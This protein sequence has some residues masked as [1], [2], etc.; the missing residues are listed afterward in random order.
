[1]LTSSLLHKLPLFLLPVALTVS[2]AS[3]QTVQGKATA[4]SQV[5][6]V[7]PVEHTQTETQT[8]ILFSDITHFANHVSF[9]AP[10]TD[11]DSA[12]EIQS[13]TDDDGVW[14]EGKAIFNGSLDDVYRDLIDPQIIGP[15]HLTKNIVIDNLT[16]TPEKTTYVMH[17]KMRYILQIA[18]DLSAQLDA[19]YDGDDLA[20]WYYISEKTSGSQLLSRITTRVL[21][22]ALDENRFSVEFRSE[23]VATM[24]KEKESRGHLEA[25]FDYW[26]QAS[27]T[28]VK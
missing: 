15:V 10:T 22:H 14:V 18:F 11:T 1:M 7:I 20:G 9:P 17:V 16:Q 21:V 19:L 12:F 3:T 26:T 5:P 6:A 28:R 8:H 4:V 25:L 23:N 2:C 24:N 27:K 13:G